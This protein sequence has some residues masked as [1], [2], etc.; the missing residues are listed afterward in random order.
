[1]LQG[2]DGA[3]LSARGQP[4]WHLSFGRADPP[5]RPAAPAGFELRFPARAGW[6]VFDTG[7]GPSGEGGLPAGLSG[8][9]EPLVIAT[10]ASLP[11]TAS[12]MLL[13][14]GLA[15]WRKRRRP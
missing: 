1:M 2:V 11:L 8:T 5:R 10:P 3:G 13:L 6:S 12:S 15:L 9:P 14:A 4:G 7:T